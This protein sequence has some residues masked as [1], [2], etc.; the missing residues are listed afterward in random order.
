MLEFEKN[1]FYDRAQWKYEGA[2]G[3]YYLNSDLTD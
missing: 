1:T 3:A 2:F